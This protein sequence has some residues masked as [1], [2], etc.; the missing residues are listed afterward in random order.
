ML[1]TSFK[2]M[3]SSSVS[4]KSTIDAKVLDIENRDMILGMS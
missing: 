1:N 4:D 3:D 2:L